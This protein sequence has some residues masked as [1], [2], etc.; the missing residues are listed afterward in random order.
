MSEVNEPVWWTMK[1][2]KASIQVSEEAPQVPVPL[3]KRKIQ[4]AMQDFMKKR[5]QAVWAV[6]KLN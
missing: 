3:T 4:A 2:R 1:R 5:I 6:Q